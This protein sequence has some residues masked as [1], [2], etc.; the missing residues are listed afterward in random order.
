MKKLK[1]ALSIFLTLVM[2]LGVVPLSVTP[3]S[4]AST[5][6]NPSSGYD[7]T[8]D[9]GYKDKYSS[10]QEA[11]KGE[12]NETFDML[13]NRK[14]VW[15]VFDEDIMGWKKNGDGFRRVL[16]H[17]DE[18]TKYVVLNSDQTETMTKKVWEPIE[19]SQDVV[20]DLNG[21]E[22]RLSDN[23]NAD[24]SKQRKEIF[25][26]SSTMFQIIDGATLTI[27]DSSMKTSADGKGTGSIYANGR[28]IDPYKYYYYNYTHRDIFHV[29]SGNL[30]IYGG[31]FQAGRTKVQK[32][33]NFSWDK[34]KAVIGQA[35]SLGVSIYEYGTGI[36]EANAALNDVQASFDKA[37]GSVKEGEADVDNALSAAKGAK[38]LTTERQKKGDDDAVAKEKKQNKP[39]DD[40][41]ASSEKVDED[42]GDGRNETV[43]EKNKRRNDEE[44][45]DGKNQE[46]ENKAKKDE[47]SKDDKNTKIYQAKKAV[48]GAAL[49][50]N[51]ITDMTNKAF[52]FAE[53]VAGLFGSKGAIMETVWGTPVKVGSEGTFVSYG[54][55]YTG[56]GSDQLL[57]NATVEVTRPK[58]S[59]K[60]G[61]AYIYDGTF[62]G[63][64]GAN[65][66]NIVREARAF[67]GNTAVTD[68]VKRIGSMGQY[69][70]ENGVRRQIAYTFGNGNNDGRGADDDY[71]NYVEGTF[72]DDPD[73]SCIQVRGGTFRNY[74]EH[75]NVG[76]HSVASGKDDE[77]KDIRFT[78][79][80]GTSGTV[81]LGVAS[82][83]EDFI[84]DG[85]IQLI[86]T[87]G[88]GALV[89]MDDQDKAD[90]N[91]YHY[92]LYCGDTELRY[93]RYLRVYPT[94]SES[95]A[96]HSFRLTTQY[97][98]QNTQQTG[99]ALEGLVKTDENGNV[100]TEVL[101]NND[102]LDDVEDS[103]AY[104]QRETFFYYPLGINNSHNYYVVPDLN[105]GTDVKGSKLDTSSAW[106]YNTPTDYNEHQINSFT[107]SDEV[108]YSKSAPH[109]IAYSN[110]DHGRLFE[111]FYDKLVKGEV[112]N[113]SWTYGKNSYSYQT[114]FKWFKYRVYRVDP[115]TRENISESDVYGEDVP[116]KEAVYGTSTNSLRC[117]LPLD[118]LGI[119]YKPGEIYRIVFD[120]DEYL[121]YN[122]D[123]R[124]TKNLKTNLKTA[125]VETSMLFM[126][127][128]G[129]EEITDKGHSY[130]EEDYTPLQ[131]VNEPE[132][133][134]QAKV[135]LVNGKTGQCD[136]NG[137]NIF[138]VYY[139]WY[140]VNSDGSEKMIAGTD[141]IFTGDILSGGKVDKKSYATKQY[142]DFAHFKAAGTY[143]N[144][145]YINSADADG[146]TYLNSI[147]PDDPNKD[148]YMENGLPR[149]REDWTGEML[150]TFTHEDRV[151]TDYTKDGTSSLYLANNKY[152][153]HNTDSCYIPESAKGK[154]VYCKVICV[155]TYWQKNYPHVQVFRTHT[156]DTVDDISV[157][158]SVDTGNYNNYV[159][160]NGSAS[161]SVSGLK[162]LKK[163]EYINYMKFGLDHMSSDDTTYKNLKVFTD[164]DLAKRTLTFPDDFLYGD[165]IEDFRDGNA[166]GRKISISLEIQT[167]LGRKF[168]F[169]SDDFTYGLDKQ[170][171]NVGW[172]LDENGTLTI[173]GDGDGVMPSY[174]DEA[175]YPWYTYRNKIKNIIVDIGVSNIGD[176]AFEG[177]KNLNSIKFN[178]YPVSKFS[179]IGAFAFA[180]S[181]ISGTV[182]PPFNEITLGEGAFYRCD[183]LNEFT[184]AKIKVIPDSAFYAC[185]KLE[186]VSTSSV[187]KIGDEAF[188]D[189]TELKTA[190]L[191]SSVQEIGA[192]AFSGTAVSS[193]DFKSTKIVGE[194]AFYDAPLRVVAGDNFETIGDKAFAFYYNEKYNDV[195]VDTTT[196]FLTSNSNKALKNYASS[197]DFNIDQKLGD[198]YFD[199]DIETSTIKVFAP[200]GVDSASTGDYGSYLASVATGSENVVPWKGGESYIKNIEIEDGVTEIGES[201]FAGI[202]AKSV[203]LPDSVT[204]VGYGAFSWNM[205]LES[206]DL[207]KVERLDSAVF[208][209]SSIKTLTVPKSCKYIGNLA[210]GLSSLS[211]ITIL[212]PDCTIYDSNY[213]FPSKCKIKAYEGSTAQNYCEA[214]AEEGNYVFEAISPNPELSITGETTRRG[215]EV[216]LDV[217]ISNNPGIASFAFDVE[218]PEGLTLTNVETHKLFSSKASGSKILTSP[219]RLQW[220]SSASENETENGTIAT[221]TF[222]VDPKA[223][224]KKY[225]IKL[226]YNTDEIV[227]NEMKPVEFQTENGYI[228]VKNLKPGDVNNDGSV[229]MKDI[230]LLQKYLNGYDVSINSTASDV[231][232]DGKINMK[233]IALLQQ[234]L[235]GWEVELK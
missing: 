22:I 21:H 8:I 86:D 235:N 51:K 16:E 102:K 44:A 214:Y 171:G 149:N 54:G 179:S 100:I 185:P 91:V 12:M 1:S 165:D 96:S 213:V 164:D 170:F 116:L 92:R 142:H 79:Y 109:N 111:E 42:K 83:N 177:Y 143:H 211:E 199:Y 10:P 108:I 60:G 152:F 203:R 194:A 115:L 204:K 205:A 64:A 128:D 198:C 232:A 182:N 212:N 224:L 97:R 174:S 84:R 150:H 189:C 209:L 163:N 148:N 35:V 81:N 61:K 127:Y 186:R 230:A 7:M 28:M 13:G 94:T 32:K 215:S 67:K 4:A 99:T 173:I 225:P 63:K 231:N 80:A 2:L 139:Q 220:Y 113:D 103:G 218:Y 206:V 3:V 17:T 226:S 180:D 93:K 221:L 172:T 183:K 158:L 210:F 59:K 229:G 156:L 137:D 160:R 162:G 197:C 25:A 167:N 20:L 114:N 88:D 62:E 154:K 126:C 95:A 31:N 159:P 52:S 43:D 58:N 131:W 166:D 155:N 184:G 39:T 40:K 145:Q 130:F 202:Q 176:H 169:S 200:Y 82:Y 19:I 223:E 11:L 26:H 89:L 101:K 27:I 49:D 217:N 68:D 122:Y 190:S 132:A 90:E 24:G 138:D 233:D 38:D 121:G 196:L 55:N 161:V 136:C 47:A 71:I 105:D 222:K 85:R 117:K 112:Q 192:N 23:Y 119:N 187:Q 135:Q 5:E 65:V 227:D 36:G 147:D 18:S 70:D 69:V 72:E 46:G 125:T 76:I 146:Y 77:G 157:K 37:L 104:S 41:K 15:E 48:I 56:Y 201:T 75:Y 9:F 228:Y 181:S 30:V 216:K 153:A 178:S 78:P 175:D 87:Y 193:F 195:D 120:V 74:F 98:N 207:N 33:K 118:E 73:T 57:R 50:E 168:K 107:Y 45:K 53:G 123:N 144:G 66:F 134:K 14:S 34:L 129:N 133:G 188:L 208:A 191:G 124:S 141:N 219:Y 151:K 106:Y 140:E 234:Y 6:N 29:D 110:R